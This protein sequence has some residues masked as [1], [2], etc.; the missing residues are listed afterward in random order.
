MNE[1][2][3]HTGSSFVYQLHWDWEQPTA[4]VGIEGF[5]SL[6]EQSYSSCCFLNARWNY[7]I[8]TL[9]PTGTAR[10]LINTFCGKTPPAPFR[11]TKHLV[12]WLLISSHT[13]WQKCC[14]IIILAKVSYDT[15]ISIYIYVYNIKQ[16][17]IYVFYV[18]YWLDE[19][20]YEFRINNHSLET[21]E[22]KKTGVI[23]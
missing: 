16:K 9:Q 2:F 11:S 22:S 19:C 23:L 18:F 5:Q 4:Y 14:Y 10:T 13:K 1:M 21:V 20:E 17:T 15:M 6:D 3:T 8:E 7:K 12:R